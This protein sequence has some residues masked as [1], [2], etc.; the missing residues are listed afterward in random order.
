MREI[1]FRGKAI[2]DG[3]W[4]YG[5]LHLMSKTPHIHD[6]FARSVHIDTSTVGQYTGLRDKNGKKI[7]EGDILRGSNGSIN[8]YEW[9]FRLEVKWDKDKCKFTVPTWGYIDSTHYYEVIGNIYD[10]PK[11]L[12]SEA[13]AN[14]TPH[15]LYKANKEAK[16]GAEIE[17]P[18]CHKVFTKE[19]YSQAFCCGKC[20]DAYHNK[21][22]PDRHLKTDA[23]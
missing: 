13:K 4:V 2:N 7:Y 19:Q 3:V 14:Y 6:T 21:R 22:N 18:S 11:L 12:E 1:E 16:V 23:E 15:D 9:P 5:D 17:C 20:K 10:N 8:G